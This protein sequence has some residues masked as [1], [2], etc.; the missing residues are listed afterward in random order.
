MLFLHINDKAHSQRS[1]VPFVARR[2]KSQQAF[3]Y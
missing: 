1:V 3:L 2:Q